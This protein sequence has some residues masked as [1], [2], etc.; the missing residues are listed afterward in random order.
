MEAIGFALI[1]PWLRPERILIFFYTHLIFYD[2][3]SLL[4]SDILLYC[5]TVQSDGTCIISLCP[6]VPML[7]CNLYI[8]RR[9]PCGVI[10]LSIHRLVCPYSYIICLSF[11]KLADGL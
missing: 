1:L 7:F 10:L 9:A 2:I 8:L 4:I 6:K 5:R 3:G 11:S